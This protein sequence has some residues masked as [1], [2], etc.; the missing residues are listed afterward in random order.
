MLV[1]A[2]HKRRSLVTRCQAY[3]YSGSAGGSWHSARDFLDELVQ[4]IAGEV[5]DRPKIETVLRP[6]AHI[7]ALDAFGHGAG[8]PCAQLLGDEQIDYVLAPLID[9]RGNRL[10]VD[11][12][13]PA[14]EQRKALRGQVDDRWRYIDPAVE[15]RLDGMLVA[16]RHIHQMARLQR[17]DMC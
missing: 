15:P 4:F 3:K 8:M 11:I 7:I 16:G 14:A 2:R 1:G 13:E 17:T 9:D 10:A 5:A 12:V 6:M